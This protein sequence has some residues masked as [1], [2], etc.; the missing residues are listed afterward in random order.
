MPLWL[1]SWITDSRPRKR[2][3]DCWRMGQVLTSRRRRTGCSTKPTSPN[4]PLSLNV[5][6]SLTN[7]RWIPPALYRLRT[8]PA[9]TITSL[10][11]CLRSAS[12]QLRSLGL[13]RAV[14]LPR[15]DT[16]A[17]FRMTLSHRLP[18]D[19]TVSPRRLQM[20]SRIPRL[21]RHT[22]RPLHHHHLP[23]RKPL[24]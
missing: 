16:R 4:R 7:T 24:L 21:L 18:L 19:S 20:R 11:P 14:C 23:H 5:Q 15:I 9:Q 1:S 3:R 22:V 13:A 12:T 2:R 10:S 6:A 17:S 8:T